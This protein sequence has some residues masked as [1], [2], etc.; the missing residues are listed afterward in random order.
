MIE[1]N[2]TLI[3]FRIARVG[4][5]SELGD[6]IMSVCMTLSISAEDIFSYSRKQ[7]FVYAR[8]II[9]G[10]M[11]NY[12]DTPF[13]KIGKLFGRTHATIINSLN[14][15]HNL[16]VSDKYFLSLNNRCVLSYFSNSKTGIPVAVEIRG[17]KNGLLLRLGEVEYEYFFKKKTEALLEEKKT[18]LKK[19]HTLSNVVNV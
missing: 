16:L 14:V 10:M 19:I 8:A 11:R 13:A 3:D 2:K 6:I 18:L 1:I 7:E 9:I 5:P 15:Y 12:H 17:M 4:A